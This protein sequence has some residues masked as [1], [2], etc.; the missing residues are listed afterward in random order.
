MNITFDT[1]EENVGNIEELKNELCT[2]QMS[3]TATGKERFDTPAVVSA[4]SIEGRP[5]KGRLRKDRYTALLLAHKYIYDKDVRPDTEIDY[6][7]VAGNI[8]QVKSDNKDEG[9]YKGPGVGQMRNANWAKTGR[10][11]VG[12][13]QDGKRI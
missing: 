5:R 13:I 4:G 11:G 9:L 12:G 6:E 1:Y 7:D 10:G 3:E 8:A 2:I